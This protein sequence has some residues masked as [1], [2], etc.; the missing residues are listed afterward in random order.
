MPFNGQELVHKIIQGDAI[1]FEKLF[2]ENFPKLYRF[3]MSFVR[4]GEVAREISQETFI[5][6]WESKETLRVDTNLEALLFTICRNQCLNF[7]KHRKVI[8][9]YQKVVYEESLELDVL[10]NLLNDD[11]F[12]NFDFDLLSQKIQQ[13]INGL[14]D[15]CQTVFR[16]SRF[17]KKK[18]SEIA[19]QLK[20]S[21][22][23]VEAHVSLALK[24]LRN[25]LKDFLPFF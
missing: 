3:S 13:T 5:R 8:L 16:L 14:P 18:Y 2:Y 6:I 22:K 11:A 21:V 23:T 25:E 15:Q 12:Q 7:L 9:K 20:I 19:I 4:N 17:G 10:A 1:A 24:K